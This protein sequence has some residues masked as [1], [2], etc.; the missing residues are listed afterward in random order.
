[1]HILQHGIKPQWVN[2]LRPRQN[3]RR[4]PDDI[5]KCIFMNENVWILIKISLKFVPKGPINDI[6]WLVQIMAWRRSGDKPLS[7]PMMVSLLT[8]ICV[9]RPQWVNSLWPSDAIC[10]HK[11]FSSSV[12]TMDSCP[13]AKSNYLNQCWLIIIEIL[14]QSPEGHFVENV[15]DIWYILDMRLE[16]TYLV[17]QLHLPRPNDLISYVIISLYTVV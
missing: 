10:H 16:I 15:Q 4:F 2:S 11:T 8:H 7:E 14:G 13:T 5:F 17:L 9:T 3:G 1:M 12:Q 6:P